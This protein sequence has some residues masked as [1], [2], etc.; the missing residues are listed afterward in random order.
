MFNINIHFSVIDFSIFPI[1]GHIL[2]LLWMPSNIWLDARQCEF[3]FF[4]WWI[5]I[6]INNLELCSGTQWRSFETVWFFRSYF[7]NQF[8]GT[9]AAFSLQLFVPYYWGKTLL[10]T[11]PN[12]LWIM[13]FSSLSGNRPNARPW[14]NVRYYSI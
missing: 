6:P 11:L 1:L 12:A 5:C 3:Y 9:G 4:G 10:R 14:V 8:S 13:R 2:L 7:Y